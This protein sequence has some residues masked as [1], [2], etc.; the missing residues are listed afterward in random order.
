MLFQ[1]KNNETVKKVYWIGFET[2]F[3]LTTG[4]LKR[5]KAD[6][7]KTNDLFYPDGADKV[8]DLF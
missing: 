5:A 2:V 4:V 3:G 7:M 8:D 1:F 6:N